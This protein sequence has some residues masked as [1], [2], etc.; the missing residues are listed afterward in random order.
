MAR[1]NKNKTNY[2][3]RAE[4]VIDNTIV[5]RYYFTYQEIA[6][7]FNL[8]PNTVFKMINKGQKPKRYCLQ[9]INF[10]RDFKPAETVKTNEFFTIPDP[11]YF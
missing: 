5:S 1:K 3:Y 6:D 8:H 2:H 7:D 4:L 10:Y 11:N 9:N